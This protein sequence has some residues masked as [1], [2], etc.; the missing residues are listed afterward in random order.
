MGVGRPG[1]LGD[2]APAVAGGSAVFGAESA[3]ARASVRSRECLRAWL[4][5]GVGRCLPV[6]LEACARLGLDPS[7]NRQVESLRNRVR[8]LL[9]GSWAGGPASKSSEVGA[10]MKLQRVTGTGARIR[11]RVS[12]PPP[13]CWPVVRTFAVLIVSNKGLVGVPLTLHNS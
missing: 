13:S 4:R 5:A 1:A 3:P 12:P 10:N 8:L 6:H 11:S 9:P 7:K 2:R